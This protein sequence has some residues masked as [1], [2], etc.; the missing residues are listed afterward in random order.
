LFFY[1]AYIY[2]L[3]FHFVLSIENDSALV[4]G[5]ITEELKKMREAVIQN[6]LVLDILTLGKRG[7]SKM[8]GFLCHFDTV[9][10]HVPMKSHC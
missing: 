10:K 5:L 9:L 3:L 1:R 4:L 8:L 2:L 7:V 6:R